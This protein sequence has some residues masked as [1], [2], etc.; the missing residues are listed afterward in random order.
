M[1][2]IYLY[3]YVFYTLVAP[4]IWYLNQ[5]GNPCTKLD[6]SAHRLS[7]GAP[8]REHVK[9]KVLAPPFPIFLSGQLFALN[10]YPL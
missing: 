8:L 9:E 2:W 5:P 1:P 7:F 10:F 6:Q 3:I 4:W